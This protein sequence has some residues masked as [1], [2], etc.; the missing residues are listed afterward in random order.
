[1]PTGEPAWH[2]G[3]TCEHGA[4]IEVGASDEAVLLRSSQ[5]P[6]VIVT[7]SRAEWREFVASVK[8]NLFD[9]V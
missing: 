5:A 8:L 1:M 7:M 4:C 3:R 9:D 6:D 2:V